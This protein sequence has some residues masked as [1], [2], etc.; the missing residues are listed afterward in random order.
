MLPPSAFESTAALLPAPG[1]PAGR[2]TRDFV[3][4]E[5]ILDSKVS[6]FGAKVTLVQSLD[7]DMCAMAISVSAATAV[8]GFVTP[9]D[10][11]DVVLTQGHGNSL[12]TITILRDVRILGVDQSSDHCRGTPDVVRTVS[13]QV[14]PEQGQILALTQHV[15]TMSLTLR[16][17]GVA[18]NAPPLAPIR[19][20]D[21]LKDKS[22]V[23]SPT[24][25]LTIKVRCG[26]QKVELVEVK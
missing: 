17:A 22:P 14:T 4:G 23:D 24:A 13:V 16:A 7:P 8:G 6:G 9:G 18:A 2:A 5:V 10:H 25:G 11:V 21:I 20:N 19:L 15:D 3:K 26:D 12:R 1:S